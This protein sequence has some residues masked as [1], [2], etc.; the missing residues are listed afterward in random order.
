MGLFKGAVS[1]LDDENMCPSSE[2]ATDAT[3][4]EG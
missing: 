2:L 4:G 3:L 1:C